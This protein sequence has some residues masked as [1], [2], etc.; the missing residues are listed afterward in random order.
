MSAATNQH[1]PSPKLRSDLIFRP[2]QVAGQTVYILEDP[3]QTKFYRLGRSEYLVLASLDGNSSWADTLTSGCQWLGD[4]PLSEPQAR[5]I[6]SWAAQNDLLEVGE[7]SAT[8]CSSSQAAAAPKRRTGSNSPIFFRIPL[9]SPEAWIAR[10]YPYLAWIYCKW[11]TV[12]G[13][14]IVALGLVA[15]AQRWDRL[16]ESTSAIFSPTGQLSLLV[17]WVLL[18]VIHELSHGLVCHRYGGTVRETG[19]QFILMLPIAYVDVT[20]AWRIRSRLQRLHISAAGMQLEL[21]VAGL[22]ALIWSATSPGIM[23]QFCANLV[24]MAGVTT[25]LFNANPL[26]RFDGYYILTD[27]LEMPNL[28]VTAHSWLRGWA[29]RFFLGL[30]RDSELKLD[31]RAVLIR[32]YAIL[33]FVWRLFV[34]AGLIVAAATMWHGAGVVLAAF[35]VITWYGTPLLRLIRLLSARSVQAVAMR[36]RMA[37]TLTAIGIVGG[38]ALVCLPWPG[39]QRVVGIVDYEPLAVVRSKTDGFV[40]EMFVRSGDSVRQGQM[41]ARLRNDILLRDHA[42]QK[43]KLAATRL[44]IRSLLGQRKLA[45]LA[46]ERQQL[47]AFEKQLAELTEQVEGLTLRAPVNGHVVSR[48][49]DSQLGVFL[50]QG[51]SL[52]QI[53][54]EAQKSIAFSIPQSDMT[55]LHTSHNI[56]VHM[57]LATGG[58]FSGRIESIQPRA[59]LEPLDPAL[60]AIF[61]GPLPVRQAA[62]DLSSADQSPQLELLEPHFTA[63]VVLDVQQSKQL[64]AGQRASV[65]LGTPR[66]SVGTHV[67]NMLTDHL[68]GPE[69]RRSL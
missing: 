60:C 20:S 66:E 22:A 25:L 30:P 5:K 8:S 53:G 10:C 6:L 17:A 68:L 67:W 12:V 45:A 64:N 56:P 49:L 61:G 63:R 41:L 69:S 33:A 16:A 3:L 32:T 29:R 37:T 19:L 4:P 11:A 2:Q 35:A 55:A 52:L 57:S 23:N 59:S 48:N 1:D 31:S 40:E 9:G 14:S 42:I 26:M 36:Y 50:H 18:K 65:V 34:C 51:E 47:A 46:A 28:A 62:S 24:L 58:R 13:V 43:T 7:Q 21:Y 54:N 38:I 27:L 44:R 39:A 15:V